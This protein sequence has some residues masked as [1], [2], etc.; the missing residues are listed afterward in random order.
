LKE[1]RK[2]DAF[3]NMPNLPTPWNENKQYLSSNFPH[4]P[5][6]KIKDPE[7]HN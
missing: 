5:A 1:E 3:L 2:G 7:C 6:M 4:K